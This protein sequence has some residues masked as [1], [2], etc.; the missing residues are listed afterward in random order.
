MSLDSLQAVMGCGEDSADERES[1]ISVPLG[2]NAKDDCA[3]VADWFDMEAEEGVE[4]GVEEDAAEAV[5][6]REAVAPEEGEGGEEFK[7]AEVEAKKAAIT[8]VDSQM[9]ENAEGPKV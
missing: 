1:G 4:E 9:E 7:S 5:G 6:D 3:V 2:V 8:E